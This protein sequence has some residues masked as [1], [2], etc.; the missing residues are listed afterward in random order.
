MTE[1]SFSLLSVREINQK[2]ACLSPVLLLSCQSRHCKLFP[3]NKDTSTKPKFITGTLPSYRSQNNGLQCVLWLQADQTGG[4]YQSRYSELHPIAGSRN[5]PL[6]HRDVDIYKYLWLCSKW[7]YDERA[8]NY[9]RDKHCIALLCIWIKRVLQFRILHRL[10]VKL[11]ER[12]DTVCSWWECDL[13]LVWSRCPLQVWAKQ[14]PHPGV[15]C[16]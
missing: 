14:L 7:N 1:W 13:T 6:T 5:S 11:M 4:S 16:D 15:R 10:S 3:V 8:H 12:S 9:S 2:C